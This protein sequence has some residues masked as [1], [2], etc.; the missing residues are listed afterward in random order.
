M[1]RPIVAHLVAL[2]L[3][4]LAC[5]LL[6]A[7]GHPW[8]GASMLLAVSLTPVRSTQHAKLL[9]I[10][11]ALGFAGEWALHAAAVTGYPPPAW[12]NAP[13]PLWTVA[14]WI[15]F[16]STTRAALPL[17]Q[18]RF[19][20]I[21]MIGALAGPA[22]YWIEERLGAITLNPDQAIWIVGTGALC[23]LAAPLFVLLASTSDT[24]AK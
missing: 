12:T 16:A 15:N 8:L 20:L 9:A 5:V 6:I 14:L 19:V 3:A 1:S 4:R 24:S 7:A 17:L 10:A 11:A 18:D 23:L 2:L 13:V 21:T 22:S